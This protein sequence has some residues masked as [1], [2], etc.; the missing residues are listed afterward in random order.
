MKDS[1][2]DVSDFEF[3]I[4]EFLSN[5]N[6]VTAVRIYSFIQVTF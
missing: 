6:P 2:V 1:E 3:T 4:A 5:D